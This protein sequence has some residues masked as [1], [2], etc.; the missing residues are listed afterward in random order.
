MVPHHGACFS[1]SLDERTAA[2]LNWAWHPDGRR[3]TLLAETGDQADVALFTMPPEG[4]PPIVTKV[5]P[6]VQAG[7]NREFMWAPSGN[8]V[9][10]EHS[11]GDTFIWNL[12]RLSVDPQT[13]AAG[14]FVRL[15]SGAGQDTRAAISRDGRTLALHDQV[16]I[17]SALDIRSRSGARGRSA[18][19]ASPLTDATAVPVNA[20]LAPDGRR[21][22]YSTSGVGTGT[23][24]LWT[25]DLTT[26]QK[27][28]LARDNHNRSDPKWSRDGSRLVYQWARLKDRFETSLAMRDASGGDETLLSPPADQLVQPHDWSPDGQSILITWLRPPRQPLLAL[29]PVAA[30]PHADTAATTVTEDPKGGLWQARYSP[31]GRWISFLTTPPGRAIVCVVPST[32]RRAG[33]GERTCLTD[34]DVWHDKPRWSS[35][36]KLLYVWRRDGLAVQRVG[37]AVRRRARNRH[38]QPS[39]GDPLRQ[40]GPRPLGRPGPGPVRAVGV[41]R[42]DD[43]AHRRCHRQHLDARQRRQVMRRELPERTLFY[44]LRK[45]FEPSGSD[46]ML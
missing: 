29:W 43:P 17:D 41:T 34:P 46:G 42:P 10:F 25:A 24:E 44:R 27:H 13:L 3:L 39:S 36:G 16:R 31:G 2:V 1:G 28:L 5:P 12:W 8:A 23:W 9:Y 11:V 6:S 33:V 22:A 4:G 14:A 20:S 7:A 26:K 19:A 38:R 30:A 18:D 37:F 21:I 15:T 40:P 35:D 32:A 45:R